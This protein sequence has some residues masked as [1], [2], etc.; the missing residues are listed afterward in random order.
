MLIE[1]NERMSR[2]SRT[3]RI[4]HILS[5]GVSLMLANKINERE[6]LDLAVLVARCGE[7]HNPP[8][9]NVMTD[10]SK[11]IIAYLK[12]VGPSK[13]IE[14]QRYANFAKTT[15]FKRLEPTRKSG[16]ALFMTQN[17]ICYLMDRCPLQAH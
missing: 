15:L 16:T 12:R 3:W 7:R 14:I 1:N 17:A 8:C 9:D 10:D 11:V 4:G 5:K 13:P 6:V 2:V